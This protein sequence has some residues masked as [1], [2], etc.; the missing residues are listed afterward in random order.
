MGSNKRKTKKRYIMQ[1]IK[2]EMKKDPFR[3]KLSALDGS[4]A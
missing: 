4:L 2:T 1:I 3:T